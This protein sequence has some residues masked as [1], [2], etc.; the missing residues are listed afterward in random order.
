MPGLASVGGRSMK[1]V[2]GSLSRESD[3]ARGPAAPAGPA[4]QPLLSPVLVRGRHRWFLWFDTW[5]LSLQCPGSCWL[6]VPPNG[7]LLHPGPPRGCPWEAGFGTGKGHPARIREQSRGQVSAC[8]WAPP[9]PWSCSGTVAPAYLCPCPSQCEP[10]L[11]RPCGSSGPRA[12]SP[13]GHS[14]LGRCSRGVSR[15]C[16]GWDKSLG[17]FLTPAPMGVTCWVWTAP[18]CHWGLL[19][20][21]VTRRHC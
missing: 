7:H 12:L 8:G 20:T 10:G 9:R 18:R 15:R 21:Q 13:M 2:S 14:E 17:P 1:E 16:F 6:A 3:G 19:S 5:V 4:L 11:S